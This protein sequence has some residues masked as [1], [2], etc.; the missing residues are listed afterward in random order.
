[1]VDEFAGHGVRFR[2]P[3]SWELT[4]QQ[5]DDG[6]A[7]TISGPGTSFWTLQLFFDAPAPEHVIL[8]AVEA[9]RAEYEEIDFYPASAELCARPAS[10]GDVEFVCLELMNSAFLRAF[11]ADRFTAL[12]LFQGTDAELEETRETLDAIT[13]S[14][15][16]DSGDE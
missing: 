10:G 16:C 2:Y 13:D 1:M 3:D 8:Q 9:F 5:N 15:R 7:V 6:V 12:V 11:Q 14:L 4:E